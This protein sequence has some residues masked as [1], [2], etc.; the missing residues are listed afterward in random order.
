MKMKVPR[1]RGRKP[2][3]DEV[4]AFLIVTTLN[5]FRNW[6][7]VDLPIASL[8][9]NKFFAPFSTLTR[10]DWKIPRKPEQWLSKNNDATT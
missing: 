5:R 6:E 8:F 10:Y 1:K 9:K 3:I 2:R 7:E 4:E